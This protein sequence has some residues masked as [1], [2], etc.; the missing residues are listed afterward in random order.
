MLTIF[1][2]VRADQT[3]VA[4]DDASQEAYNGGFD[5]GKNGGSGFGEWKMTTEGNRFSPEAFTT[6]AWVL[7][8]QGR[9]NEATQVMNRV[10]QTG[11]LSQDG[12]YYLARILSDQKQ[13]EN[14]IKLLDTALAAPAPFAQ[15]DKAAEL[16]TQL[17]KEL[18]D[19][20]EKGADSAPS[21][22]KK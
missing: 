7:Y 5:T 12:A 1:G 10:L 19:K 18:K 17:Q 9:V 14:A 15:R 6:A 2:L 21:G 3:N 4:E 8:R 20:G 11:Q 13:T 16:R 22:E